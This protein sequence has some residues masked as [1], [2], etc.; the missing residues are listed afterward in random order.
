MRELKHLLVILPVAALLA[1]PLQAAEWQ[2]LFNGHDLSG[3]QQ[4]GGTAKYQ[5]EGNEIVGYAVPNT[6]NSFLT[7]KEHFSDFIL[8][9]EILADPTM[10]SGVQ[11]RD[12]TCGDLAGCTTTGCRMAD[13]V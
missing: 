8:E 4:V 1:A 11:I 9:Y 7:T 12:S 3:W 6:P 5:A 2:T 10:N 13:L